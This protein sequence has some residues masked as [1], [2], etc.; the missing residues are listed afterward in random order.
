MWFVEKFLLNIFLLT[1]ININL[2][3]LLILIFEKNN[4]CQ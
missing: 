4:L 2:V 1:K 3:Y